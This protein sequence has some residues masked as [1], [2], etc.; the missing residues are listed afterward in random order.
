MHTI[1]EGTHDGPGDPRRKIGF[2]L[3]AVHPFRDWIDLSTNRRNAKWKSHFL[4]L[5]EEAMQPWDGDLTL[6]LIEVLGGRAVTRRM[7]VEFALR[8]TKQNQPMATELRTSVS[9]RH[10]PG[11]RKGLRMRRKGSPKPRPAAAGFVTQ[12]HA[13]L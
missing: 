2:W 4:L 12:G 8:V 10:N 5:S 6:K 3:V 11:Q 7:F 13:V 1:W 9:T